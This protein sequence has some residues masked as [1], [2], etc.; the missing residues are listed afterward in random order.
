MYSTFVTH[1]FKGKAV[2]PASENTVILFIA[3]CFENNLAAATVSTY[4]SALSY[5]HK[6]KNLPDPT[7]NFVVKKCLQGYQKIKSQCDTRK[8]ITFMILQQLITSLIHVYVCIMLKA[9]YLLAFFGM[10]RV[11]E[12]T[13]SSKTN[14]ILHME[15]VRF[16]YQDKTST[17]SSFELSISGYKHSQGR[18][19]ILFIE[20][21][22]K[23]QALCPVIALWKYFQLRASSSGPLFSFMDGSPV[24][25]SFFTKQL[26]LSL[27]WAG[28]NTKLYK[29]HSFRIGRATDL[30]SQG[31]SEDEIS[32][33]GRWSS[34]A[35][36]NYIRVPTIR[37]L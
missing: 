35:V 9:M 10:L 14:V 33:L 20:R 4:V 3:N 24:S 16:A 22:N 23:A 12:F 1:R 25:R 31:M 5:Y 34:S 30:A 11:G 8:P 7:N 6:I 28:C 13:A 21:N 2:L 26:Y 29:A 15:N 18:T 36:K 37:M 32:R 19:T 17:P 27:H